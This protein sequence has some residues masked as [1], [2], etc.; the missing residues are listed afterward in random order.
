MQSRKVSR[1][2]IRI[3]T[4]TAVVVYDVSF[5][6]LIGQW[7]NTGQRFQAPVLVYLLQDCLYLVYLFCSLPVGSIFPLIDSISPHK[8][9]GD[10]ECGTGTDFNFIVIFPV[11]ILIVPEVCCW[12]WQHP[13]MGAVVIPDSALTAANDRGNKL[14]KFSIP[15]TRNSTYS[16]SFRSLR[17]SSSRRCSIIRGSS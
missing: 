12:I 5:P 16:F 6:V 13:N 8:T 2:P 1:F 10:C 3:C 17:I 9:C 15:P 11:G 14:V 7:I 4:C